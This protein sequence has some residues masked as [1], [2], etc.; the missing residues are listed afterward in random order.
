MITVPDSSNTVSLTGKDS[1]SGENQK[2]KVSEGL[3]FA[4][5]AA[6]YETVIT[7]YTGKAYTALNSSSVPDA[8]KDVVKNYFSELSE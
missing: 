8:M 7:S 5:T 3:T 1:G 4:G 6:D 2:S